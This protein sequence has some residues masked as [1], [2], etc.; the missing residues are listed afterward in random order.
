MDPVNLRS[1]H[2]DRKNPNGTGVARQRGQPACATWHGRYIISWVEP[3]SVASRDQRTRPVSLRALISA[4]PDFRGQVRGPSAE[5]EEEL[6]R[7]A[8]LGK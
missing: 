4:E 1:R 7:V 6:E 5:P 2:H 8:T 3:A